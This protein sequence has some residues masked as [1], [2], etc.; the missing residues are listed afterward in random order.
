MS[1]RIALAVAV[2]A[3]AWLY[4]ST[5]SYNDAVA[6]ETDYCTQVAANVWPDYKNICED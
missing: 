3:A 4:V 2:V 1:I 5:A 6:F